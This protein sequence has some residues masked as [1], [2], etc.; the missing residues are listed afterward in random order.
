MAQCFKLLIKLPKTAKWL[1]LFLTALIPTLLSVFYSY[2]ETQA[3]LNSLG[4]WWNMGIII[5]VGLF[6]PIL[7]NI[8]YEKNVSGNKDNLHNAV[9]NV[10]SGIDN[11]V[12]SKRKRFYEAIE[13]VNGENAFREITK[14]VVQINML[15]SALC[16]IVSSISKDSRLKSTLILCNE[17]GLESYLSV[18]GDDVP[19]I[20]IEELNSNESLAKHV[21]VT[22]RIVYIDN[23]SIDTNVVFY[24]PQ[25]CKTKSIYCYPIKVGRI[26]KLILCFSSSKSGMF[27]T[28]NMEILESVIKEF[29]DRMLLECHLYSMIR[30]IQNP[31]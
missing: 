22:G 2:G 7:G 1:Q 28:G 31:Q 16:N 11:V 26:V 5:V 4:I 3:Y 17:S 20:Q 25:Y 8:V 21:F 9:V 27:D 10:L 29:A 13:R 19:S 24:K 12:E 23:T 6:L 18:V 14:P 15:A 30:N